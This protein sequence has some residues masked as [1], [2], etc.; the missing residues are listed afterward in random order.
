MK[1]TQLMSLTDQELME[2]DGG[3]LPVIG[4]AGGIKLCVQI[5]GM[6]LAAGVSIGIS[7]NKRK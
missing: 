7:R 3:V 1:N 2:V 6:G 5:F 4:V